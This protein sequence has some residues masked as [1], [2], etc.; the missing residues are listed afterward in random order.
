MSHQILAH[1]QSKV[2]TQ[3]GARSP[4]RP[5]YVPVAELT[6]ASPE[7]LAELAQVADAHAKYWQK[8]RE[9]AKREL[10]RRQQIGGDL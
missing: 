7:L 1:P 4:A 5:R 2:N 9:K 8:M 10:A 6:D 3:P